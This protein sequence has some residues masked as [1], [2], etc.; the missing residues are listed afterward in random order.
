M[1]LPCIPQHREISKCTPV[2]TLKESG[3]LPKE[4]ATFIKASMAF[5]V[6]LDSCTTRSS[7][8]KAFL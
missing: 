2:Y 8:M 4:L 7:Q 6:G 5:D 3:A 1:H